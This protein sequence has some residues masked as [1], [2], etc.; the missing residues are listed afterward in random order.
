M[1]ILILTTFITISH[2]CV[3]IN[4]PA[5]WNGAI[6]HNHPWEYKIVKDVVLCND[7]YFLY[8][9]Y[10]YSAI[11][12]ENAT[13]DCNNA[14]IHSV[15]DIAGWRGTGI[16]V[17]NGII[18]NCKV[19]K[20][21]TGIY[22]NNSIIENTIINE[23]VSGLYATDSYLHDNHISLSNYGLT[24]N[25]CE[26]SNNTIQP[27][28]SYGMIIYNDCAI[29][30]N[31]INGAYSNNIHG[32]GVDVRGNDNFF[33]DN[34][35]MY[36][37]SG[38]KVNGINNNFKNDMFCF[39]RGRRGLVDDI[40]TV[41]NNVWNNVTCSRGNAPCSQ[42][43]YHGCARFSDMF[44]W[45]GIRQVGTVY[46]I[47]H[48]ITLCP[49]DV[50][51]GHPR[52]FHDEGVFN[53]INKNITID[54]QNS[55]INGSRAWNPVLYV[56]DS[57]VILK[58]CK[59]EDGNIGITLHNSILS[60]QDSSI[61]SNARSGIES[62]SSKIILTNL[63][64]TQHGKFGVMCRNSQCNMSH[65]NLDNARDYAIY[66]K[67]SIISFDTV[68]ANNSGYGIYTENSNVTGNDFNIYDSRYGG[69][70]AVDSI[71]DLNNCYVSQC[72]L[73]AVK[74][75]NSNG[76]ITNSLFMGSKYRWTVWIENGMMN[77]INDTV[78]NGL[79][80]GVRAIGKHNI[81]G[82]YCNN[83][84]DMEVENITFVNATCDT[85]IPGGLC[86][87]HCT[88]V[89]TILH[90]KVVDEGYNPIQNAEV[91]VITTG[92]TYYTNSSG[93]FVINFSEK[94]EYK[95]LISYDGYYSEEVTV[96]MYSESYKTFVL[97][98]P[99]F[100]FG[101]IRVNGPSNR[102][103][104]VVNNN[105]VNFTDIIPIEG[106]VDYEN[107]PTGNYTI[108]WQTGSTSFELFNGENKIIN[109]S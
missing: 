40:T 97:H 82:V 56:E 79:K 6:Q 19:S 89:P 63:D 53:I 1:T 105:I 39:S 74:S 58:N 44:T 9:P 11:I 34:T 88:D 59:I 72:P 83:N 45:E 94:G 107:I 33:E 70:V 52:P 25:G 14:H 104:H 65:V 36:T 29:R 85:S 92:D 51:I 62:F 75:S 78:V 77:F 2:A 41:D 31:T 86:I 106:Y 71:L 48:N 32:G 57:N 23:T 7:D 99:Q 10:Y 61:K 55:V 37:A 35:V 43:C 87:Q 26:I 50:W 49:N 47:I 3:D 54:C 90:G 98:K 18:K 27:Y 103:F 30:D 8:A 4:N 80:G 60:L 109:I 24:C 76:E 64:I 91:D 13:L 5:T 17:Y 84:V 67:D 28:R 101:N 15:M 93:E 46:H 108:T 38:S 12:V 96:P 68:N 21:F 81:T 69:I 66:S 16:T 42:E 95:L 22:S 102:E 73:W 20:Y 100:G